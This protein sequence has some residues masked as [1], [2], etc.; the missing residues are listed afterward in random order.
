MRRPPAPIWA[1]IWLLALPLG[2]CITDAAIGPVAVVSGASIILT[3]GT[4]VD[5][6]ASLVTG[7]NCS[8]VHL[9]RREPWCAPAYV[10]PV[11]PFCTRS[12][13][14]VD[15][16]AWTPPGSQRQAADPPAPR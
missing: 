9:E 16:W 14:A 13:G 6:I 11:Q 15:C 1:Q 2:G 10:A 8:I 5:H 7:Q 3:G 12:L 4:P